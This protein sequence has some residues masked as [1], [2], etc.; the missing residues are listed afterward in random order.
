MNKAIQFSGGKDS[1]VCLHLF[2]DEPDI[3]AIFTNT[4]NAFPHVLDFVSE[5]CESFGV[6][7]IIAE[8]EKPVIQWHR[9]NG[10]PSDIVPW[11][12]TPAMN[13]VS[14]N[15]FGETLVPYTDCCSANVWEPMHKAVV[16]NDIKYVIRGSKSCDSKVGV[17]DGFVDE[18]G[19]YYHSPLWDWTD[20]DVFDYIAEH[21]LML[22]DQYSHGRN[23][24]LDCWCCTAY[25][26]KSGAA[27]ISYTKEKYP[28]LYDIIQPN[29][30]AVNAT[31]KTALNHY[32]EGF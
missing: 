25:M 7:L 19:V 21:K 18:G 9:D 26:G 13:G 6:P 15:D 28:E 32:A 4:G 16:D 1:I 30:L 2:K 10:F 29:I 20:K 5:I 8:P 31:I 24:S 3:K 17:P 14:E 27:R 23:D 11:D 22:P 12:S